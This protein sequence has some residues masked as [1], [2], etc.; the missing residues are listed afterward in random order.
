MLLLLVWL[1]TVLCV[2]WM[3]LLPTPSP[4]YAA[5]CI[6]RSHPSHRAS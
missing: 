4:P 6:P 1:V 2:L 5:L 3:S